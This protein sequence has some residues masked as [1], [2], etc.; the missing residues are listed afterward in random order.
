[1]YEH[2]ID[3]PAACRAPGTIDYT[4]W[5]VIDQAADQLL[6]VYYSR[7]AILVD[8]KEIVYKRGHDDLGPFV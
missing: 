1:M 7:Q 4:L 8:M 6:V 2:A 3:V 5:K